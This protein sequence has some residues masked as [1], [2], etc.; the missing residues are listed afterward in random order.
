[1]AESLSMI[2]GRMSVQV[3]AFIWVWCALI[4]GAGAQNLPDPTRPPAS[5]GAVLDGAAA[6]SNLGPRLQSVLIAPGRR[7]A[8]VSGQM[9]EVGGKVGEAK[10]VAISESEVV[11]KN[12]KDVQ[13]LKL[14]P[15]I[16]KHPA[17]AAVK[18]RSRPGSQPVKDK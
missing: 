2:A 4:V 18:S 13:I 11:L 17:S 14:F 1:M 8:I 15:D 9:V 5:L 7:V 10:V 6:E 12:G 16:E 3:A